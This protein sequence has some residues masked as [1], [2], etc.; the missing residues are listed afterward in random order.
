MRIPKVKSGLAQMQPMKRI[1][2]EAPIPIGFIFAIGLILRLMV[3]VLFWNQPLTIVD[4]QHYDALARN[5]VDTNTYAI[6]EGK[7]TA[8]RPPLYPAFIAVMY[9]ISGDPTPNWIRI[10]QVLI[11]SLTI[12][13]VYRAGMILFGKKAALAAAL[14]MALYPSHIIFSQLV[15]TEVLFTFLF[16]GFLLLAVKFLNRHSSQSDIN[17][18]NGWIMGAISLAF[19]AGILYGLSTLTRSIIYPMILPLTASFLLLKGTV[20]YRIAC[21]ALFL[22]GITLVVGPWAYRNTRL[23]GQF[24]PVGTMGGLNL[25]MGNYEYTPLNRAWATVDITGPEAWYHGHEDVLRGMNEAQKQVWAIKQA[26]RFIS[27]NRVLT[28]KRSIVKAANFWG[29]ERSVIGGLI[30]NHWPEFKTKAMII[31]VGGAIVGGYALV[32]LM[33][34]MGIAQNLVWNQ[35]PI[36]MLLFWLAYFTGMHALVFGH[37]RYHLP[38]VPVLALFAGWQSAYLNKLRDPQRWFRTVLGAAAM[39]LLSAIWCREVI[40]VEGARWLQKG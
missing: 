2:A 20:R 36:W 28:V 39:M 10:T 34:A 23:F 29:L 25:Y 16:F 4:E 15:L 24:V 6:V 38:L 37:S 13:L 40:W 1:A 9:W 18:G 32:A 7:P 26:K 27:E 3:L 5:I 19:L 8:M 33:A 22:C 35:W 30:H 17:D 11:G 21:A 31:L 12:L 14:I